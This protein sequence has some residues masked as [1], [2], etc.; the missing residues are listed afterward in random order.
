MT[1][2]P[3]NILIRTILTFISLVISA[4]VLGKQTIAQMTYL[5]FI[6]SLAIGNIGASIAYHVSINPLNIIAALFYF[7]AI[8]FSASYLSLKSRSIRKIFAGEPTVLIQNG[9][10]LERNM[11]KVHYSID[12]LNHQLREKGFFDI[13]KVEMAI[14]EPSGQ[15]SVLPKSEYRS[16]T[17]LDLNIPVQSENLAVEL[18]IDGQII[19]KNLK[20]RNLSRDWLLQSLIKHGI[21]SISYVDY[22]CLSTKGTLYIDTKTD[23]I[24]H[25]LDKE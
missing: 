21:K 11:A 24:P 25:P 19:E 5:D 9:K 13:T 15:L 3:L 1:F 18:I 23:N 20:D 12:F 8:V 6:A 4:R 17:P 7:T 22:A 2:Q 16:L 10:I 14:L